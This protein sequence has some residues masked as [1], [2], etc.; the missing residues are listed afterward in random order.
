MS[1]ITVLKNWLNGKVS[2]CN[3]GDTGDFGSMPELGRS[4]GEGN[5][6]LLQYSCLENPM[7]SKLGGLQSI[8]LQRFGYNLSD[9][10]RKRTEVFFS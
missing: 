9:L 1:L 7:H 8:Q 4:P 10:A 3:A 2:A 5:D 6:N